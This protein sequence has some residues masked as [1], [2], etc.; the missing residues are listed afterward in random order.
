MYTPGAEAVV[1]EA[2]IQILVAQVVAA[3]LHKGL[4]L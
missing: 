3:A 4:F 1:A 2:M